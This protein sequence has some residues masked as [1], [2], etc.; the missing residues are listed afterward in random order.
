MN[1]QRQYVLISE[2]SEWKNNSRIHNQRNL[3]TIKNSLQL[4]N[5]YF[6]G[7]EKFGTNI[8]QHYH[9]NT[10]EIID[11]WTDVLNILLEEIKNKR[12]FENM[13]YSIITISRQFGSGGRSIGKALAET[14]SIPYY[15][16]DVVALVAEKTGL[17]KR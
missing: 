7:A 11:Y 5:V 16:E 8:L 3:L 10:T 13:S 4:N 12:D 1:V 15:D 14:L 9:P 17:M 6:G 2:L